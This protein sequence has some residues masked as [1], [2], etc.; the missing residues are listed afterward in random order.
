ME[1]IYTVCPICAS[2]IRQ[3]RVKN[4]GGRPYKIDKCVSCGYAFVN[5]RP[6]LDFLM[7][8]YSSSG[9]GNDVMYNMQSVLAQ[10]ENEPNS[11]VDARRMIGTVKTLS[12]SIGSTKFLD[13]GCGYGFFSREA[14]ANGFDVVAMEVAKNERR[15]SYDMTGIAPLNTAFEN[16]DYIEASFGIVLMSQILEHARDINIWMDKAHKLAAMN[17]I[18]AIALPNFGS[19]FRTIMQEH[20]PYIYPPAHLNYFNQ[21]NLTML[22]RKHGFRVEKVQHISRVPKSTLQRRIPKIGKPLLPIFDLAFSV[23][24]KCVDIL[25]LGSIINVYG[26]K[27]A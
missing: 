21:C 17:G 5:P 14:L 25:R 20:E 23:S 22:L 24:L 8:F 16:F 1:E 26:R 2:Y 6:S 9:H 10:E 18:I 27:V 13:I 19:V 12:K 15:I 3:W 4:V 11:T 7:D